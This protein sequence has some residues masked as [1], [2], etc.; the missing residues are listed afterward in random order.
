MPH[1][2][3]DTGNWF[4]TTK[5]SDSFIAVAWFLTLLALPATCV[6]RCG[7]HLIQAPGMAWC[8][9]GQWLQQCLGV[10]WNWH[11]ETWTVRGTG[12]QACVEALKRCEDLTAQKT[13]RDTL[14][15]CDFVNAKASSSFFQAR[16]RPVAGERA[17]SISLGFQGRQ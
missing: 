15:H 7:L 2:F 4:S 6:R 12:A 5:Q 16:A 3:R 10:R 13:D 8:R 11:R 14:Q 1:R 9:P 17:G